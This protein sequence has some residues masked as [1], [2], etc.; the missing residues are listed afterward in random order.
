MTRRLRD[1]TA[2]VLLAA[3]LVA[4]IVYLPGEEVEGRP[5]AI[6]GDSL[7]VGGREIRLYAIDAPEGRQRCERSD[8]TSWP[9]G[10][11][12]GNLLTRL[13]EA[14]AV[15]C[16]GRDEDRYGRLVATCEAGGVDLGAEMVRQGMALAYRSHSTAYAGEEAEAQAA[17]RGVWAGRFEPPWAWREKNNGRHAPSR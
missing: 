3:A 8:G 15:T 14:A 17:R 1:W 12:A 13:A 2:A 11:D 4:A 6:D 10:K 16:K 9:C 5:V 7:R